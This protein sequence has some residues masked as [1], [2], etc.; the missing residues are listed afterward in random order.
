MKYYAK[1]LH[2]IS[3]QKYHLFVAVG[4]AVV[5]VLVGNYKACGIYYRS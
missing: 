1:D 4:V 5:V 2:T 3:T